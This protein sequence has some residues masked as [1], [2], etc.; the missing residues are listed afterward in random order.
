[1]TALATPDD[2]FAAIDAGA[3]IMLPGMAARSKTDIAELRAGQVPFDHFFDEAWF[4]SA[5]SSAC[6][7][8]KIYKPDPDKPLANALPNSYHARSRRLDD[9]SQNT[10]K[11]SLAHLDAWLASDRA[12]PTGGE[13]FA[14]VASRV[15]VARDRLLARYPARTVLLVTHVTPIKTLVR[16]ALGAPPEAM[17]RMELYAASLTAVAYYADGNASVW[18]L[19]ATAHLR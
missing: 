14:E 12:A 2:L 8:M 9:D 19:N 10:R 4:L 17:F 7:Q 13:S 5:M 1:M 16:Q 18:L 6:P 11:A 15:A 3:S